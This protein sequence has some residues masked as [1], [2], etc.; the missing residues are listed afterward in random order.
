MKPDHIIRVDAPVGVDPLVIAQAVVGSRW[1][2]KAEPRESAHSLGKHR[3]L[4]ELTEDFCSLYEK[5]LAEM[6]EAFVSGLTDDALS[7]GPPKQRPLVTPDQLRKLTEMIRNAHTA[8][9]IKGL[10]KESVSK[11]EIQNLVSRGLLPKVALTLIDDAFMYG[12]L[13][14]ELTKLSQIDAAKRMPFK[15]FEAKIKAKPIKTTHA[16]REAMKYARH[17][18]A[19]YVTGLGDRVANDLATMTSEASVA[20]GSKYRKIIRDETTENIERRE[21]VRKL[22]SEIGHKT[23]DWARDLRRIAATEKERAMQEGQKQRLIA[24]HG[25]PSG[26][27]VSKIPNPDAC[28]H[29]VALHLTAGTGSKPR[30]FKLSQLEANG[31]NVGRKARDWK[32]VVGPVHPWCACTLVHV[33]EGWEYNSEGDLV[34]SRIR[35]ASTLTHDLRKAL[36]YGRDSIPEHGVSVRVGDPQII[37]VIDDVIART[38]PALFNRRVGVTLITTDH[39]HEGNSYLLDSDLA[40]WTGN[41]IRIAQN[42]PVDRVKKVLEHELGHALNVYLMHKFGGSKL[43]REWHEKLDKISRSEGYVSKYAMTSPIENAAEV[44]RMYLYENEKLRARCP[45]QYGFVHR[46]YAP[47][48]QADRVQEAFGLTRESADDL[49]TADELYARFD[50]A[51]NTHGM[52]IVYLEN[53]ARVYERGN[54]PEYGGGGPSLALLSGLHGE[55]R[56][57][58]LALLQWMEE[59]PQ[60]ELVPEGCGVLICPLFAGRAWNDYERAPGDIDFNDVWIPGANGRDASVKRLEQLFRETNIHTFLDLHE[61]AHGAVLPYVYGYVKDHGFAPQLATALD[62]KLVRWKG[63]DKASLGASETYVRGLGCKRTATVETPTVSPLAARV[64]FQLDAVRWAA[65]QLTEDV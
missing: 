27:N 4:R 34:I 13:L 65:A 15:E 51:A 23:G 16:E 5:A 6:I 50:A 39:P 61:D 29:C 32:A 49:L 1:L 63:S 47:I 19:Q 2:V 22:A 10:G 25:D 42:L 11:A 64:A 17:Q 37:A 7:K 56:A 44:T 24:R 18:A 35:K 58:P 20:L 8:F 52:N 60:G 62:A 46:E 40:Y 45:R 59:T 26:I 3:A 53:G 30:I 14:G 43:V 12:Q 28:D 38:P 55:E 33:P 36:S 31:T 57:G 48:F 9:A 21:T 54:V 41:E